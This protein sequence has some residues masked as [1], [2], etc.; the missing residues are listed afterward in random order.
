MRPIRTLPLALLLGAALLVG[1]AACESDEDQPTAEPTSAPEQ[2]AEKVLT[3]LYWQAPSLPLSYQAAG[4]KDRDAGAIVLEPLAVTAPD[5]SVVPRLA[6]EVPSAENGGISDD[7]LTITWR[8]RPNLTWSDGSAL[9]AD[10]VVFTWIYCTTEE[11]GCLEE[12]S[13][14][15]FE[16]VEAD[17]DL[18]IV[19][20]LT[21]KQQNPERL[22][23][24]TSLPI[25]SRAQFADCMAVD[26]F[27]CDEEHRLPLGSGP[28]RITEFLPDDRV[29]Y[30]RNENYWG[31]EPY[32]DRVILIGGGD[33]ETS[34]RAVLA[35]G[36]A[37]YGWN[38]QILPTQLQELVA[39]GHGDIVTAFAS[40][41]ERIIINQTNPHTEVANNRSE[42]LDGQNPHPFLTFTPIPQA[43]SMAIDRQGIVEVLY[44]AA[45]MAAC[46]LVTAPPQFVSENNDGCLTQ[47]IEAAN[48]LL[49]E[50]GVV[51]SDGDGVREY[52][53]TP[54][55][56]TFQTTANAVRESTFALL[57]GWWDEI[58][59]ESTLITHDASVFFGGDPAEDT[60]SYRRFLADVQ[61]YTNGSGIDPEIYLSSYQC[62]HIQSRGNMWAEDNNAR[63]C[64]E[65]YDTLFTQLARVESGPAREALIRDLN[66]ILVEKAYEIPLVRRGLVS[67]KANTL[68]GVQTNAW[69]SELWN[70]RDW[71]RSPAT[72]E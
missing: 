38:L 59:I 27:S 54:L 7:G 12:H 51:D 8:L 69:D 42:Y 40:D 52:N 46:N 58:G 1:L 23:A 57:Q 37:D 21:E 35:E 41:V 14:S 61:M 22:L 24:S 32:F 66:D 10:D 72:P 4:T 63:V 60:E 45:G 68:L 62:D 19:F 64:D 43:M 55:T 17:G 2:P 5:G 29:E 56:I 13:F 47:D 36:S 20:T 33:A 18:E 28:Y 39:V 50:N 53:G 71:R 70:I 16:S 65:A 3:L 26:P 48:N 49:D 6:A 9:T 11:I 44:G 15:V 34:A 67:A 30:E 31:Q 25:I